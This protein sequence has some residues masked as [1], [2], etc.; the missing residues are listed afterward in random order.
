[1]NYLIIVDSHSK[2][3]EVV[4][5]MSTTA[6]KT[7]DVLRGLFAS[8][9]LPEEVVPDNSRCMSIKRCCKTLCSDGGAGSSK[10]RKHAGIHVRKN[11]GLRTS[12]CDIAARHTP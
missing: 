12:C 1:M 3:L 7:I 10:T 6:S 8:H 5:M 9:G 11:I 2:W 4:P